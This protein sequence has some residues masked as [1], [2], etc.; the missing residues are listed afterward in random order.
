MLQHQK[1]DKKNSATKFY[2][3][4][5]VFDSCMPESAPSLAHFWTE[6]ASSLSDGRSSGPTIRPVPRTCVFVCLCRYERARGGWLDVVDFP[7]QT[8]LALSNLVQ[9][10]DQL[11]LCVCVLIYAKGR[12]DLV[13]PESQF[14]YHYL[15]YGK[16]WEL[17]ICYQV[18]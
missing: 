17:Y 6:K 16:K 5:K 9:L 15:P 11:L 2:K 3:D 18:N 13:T 4:I 1:T 7:E 12:S 8:R 10:D 14:S